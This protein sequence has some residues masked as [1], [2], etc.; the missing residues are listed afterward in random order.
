M[1]FSRRLLKDLTIGFL[2]VIQLLP[3][4]SA[5]VPLTAFDANYE[6]FYGKMRAADAQISL[7]Q[8]GDNW[9]WLLTTR[10]RG[11]ASL[12]TSKNPYAE[13][14]F[15]RIDGNH[16]IQ[17]LIIADDAEKAKEVET[18]KFDWNSQQV[19]MLRNKEAN[20]QPLTADVYDNLSIHLFSAKM[21]DEKLPQ[22][23]VDFYYKGRV[24]KSELKQLAKTS[25]TVNE[26]EVAVMVVEQSVQDSSTKYTYYY[27]PGSPY[28]PMKIVS[29]KPDKTATTWLYV[30]TK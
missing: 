26:N 1:S 16:R 24:V 28:I 18:A 14:I 3:A 23:S 12:L 17:Q 30:P 13:T 25:I 15:T 4:V 9:R 22:A 2:L 10:P 19:E 27:D 5:E 11:L 7:S 29:G 6:L 20:S 21:L 8:A